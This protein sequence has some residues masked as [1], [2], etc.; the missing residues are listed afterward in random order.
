MKKRL[1]L[2][3]PCLLFLFVACRAPK[4]ETLSGSLFVSDAGKSH[5]GFEYNAEW[6]ATLDVSGSSGTLKLVLNVGLG[7]ALN[8]HEFIVTD[9]TRDSTRIS[10]K[11]DGHPVTLVWVEKDVIWDG[12]YDKYY[13]ASRGND[14]PLEEIRGSISP[15]DFPGLIDSY[16]VELRLR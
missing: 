11:L 12:K 1:F 16:Y 3:L 7:D 15:K 2:L 9:F 6:N 10:M 8:K 13:I 14:S 5:G 4:S